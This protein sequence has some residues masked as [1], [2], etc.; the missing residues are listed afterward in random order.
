[1]M[2]NA[3]YSAIPFGFWLCVIIFDWELIEREHEI[4]SADRI[5]TRIACIMETIQSKI[6]QFSL[7]IHRYRIKCKTWKLFNYF[8]IQIDALNWWWVMWWYNVFA[9]NRNMRSSRYRTTSAETEWIIETQTRWT[10]GYNYLSNS[11]RYKSK[12]F[13]DASRFV[14]KSVK[15]S[16]ISIDMYVYDVYILV[17]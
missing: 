14:H 12:A 2:N 8:S 10:C 4:K 5:C 1:M 7:D 3:F 6:H 9:E 11:V 15:R 16:I 13:S 17:W